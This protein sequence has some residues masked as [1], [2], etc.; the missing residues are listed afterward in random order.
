M[1][2]ETSIQSKPP[3][4]FT[5]FLGRLG[6]TLLEPRKTFYDMMQREMGILEPLFLIIVF[7]GIQGALVG[8]FTVRILYSF[9]AFLSPIIGAEQLQAFQGGLFIVPFITAIS[10]IVF[11]LMIWIISA[12]ITHLCAKY[13]FKGMGS[14]TQLL[15]LYGY[16]SVPSSL[17]ILG[18][19]LTSLNFSIFFGLS[20]ILCLMAVFWT[21]IILVVAVERCYLIDPGQAFISSFIVP[22][23]VYLALSA[24]VGLIFSSLV[25]GGFSL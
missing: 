19:M 3:S 22:L 8:V 1:E 21:V 5:G 13:I 11:A 23:I 9:L 2:N 6:G 16:A 10:W 14:Y 24:L 17:V 4:G 25:L 7:F 20:M 15:K 12:G 18:M